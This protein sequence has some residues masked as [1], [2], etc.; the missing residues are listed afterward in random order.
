MKKNN[1]IAKFFGFAPDE[2]EMQMI[3]EIRN[4]YKSLEVVGR[5]TVRIDPKEVR[6]DPAF[7]AFVEKAKMLVEK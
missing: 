3:E 5:G 7:I 6:Q 2:S 1:R 4:S